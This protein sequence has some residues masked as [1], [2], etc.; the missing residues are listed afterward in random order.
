MFAVYVKQK[1]IRKTE[2]KCRWL[3]I[4]PPFVLFREAGLSSAFQIAPPSVISPPPS[5]IRPGLFSSSVCVL[6]LHLSS[7]HGSRSIS[8]W[9]S[10][11]CLMPS[12]VDPSWPER[13]WTFSGRCGKFGS[14][15]GRGTSHVGTSAFV[16]TTISRLF[17]LPR[18]SI[19]LSFPRSVSNQK[20][21]QRG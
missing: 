8:L 2:S 15:S 18:P 19:I 10:I 6:S 11:G 20:V 14:F 3:A 1:S 16:V 9:L 21:A 5:P 17:T 7:N 4:A 13:Q 12:T